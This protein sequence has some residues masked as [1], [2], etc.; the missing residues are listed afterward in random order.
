MHQTEVFVLCAPFNFKERGE[1]MQPAIDGKQYPTI[2]VLTF[3]TTI[4]IMILALKA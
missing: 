4:Y 2:A 3:G 1:T